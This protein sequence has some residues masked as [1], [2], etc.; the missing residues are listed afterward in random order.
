MKCLRNGKE[1]FILG[2]HWNSITSKEWF[3]YHLQD[4]LKWFC[5]STKI[6]TEN[7][8]ICDTSVE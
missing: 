3:N 5:T 7:K 2:L 6:N 4:M 8:T 1:N